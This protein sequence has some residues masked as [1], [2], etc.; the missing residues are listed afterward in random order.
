MLQLLLNGPAQWEG[1][2]KEEQLHETPAPWQGKRTRDPHREL[3]QL[4][5]RVLT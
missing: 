3:F 2:A 5:P 1:H 4:L